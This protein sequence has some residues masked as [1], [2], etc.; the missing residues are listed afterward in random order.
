MK[1]LK[2]IY[3]F[4]LIDHST[5]FMRVCL[6]MLIPCVLSEVFCHV[7][8]MLLGFLCAVVMVASANRWNRHTCDT[9]QWWEPFNG[10]CCNGNSPNV[11]DFV[12]DGCECWERG[13]P[14]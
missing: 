13:C 14:K 4:L 1:K 8:M 5:G 9:C 3:W 7:W 6:L 2:K 12:D 11:A 10:V